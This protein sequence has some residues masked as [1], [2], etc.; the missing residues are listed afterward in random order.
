MRKIYQRLIAAKKIASITIC[1]LKVLKNDSKF[2]EFWIRLQPRQL[3]WILIDQPYFVR[4]SSLEYFV[5]LVV[6]HIIIMIVHQKIRTNSSY[7]FEVID[8]IVGEV[9][10]RF[11]SPLFT[12]M[13]VIAAVNN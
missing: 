5:N 4:E 2:G 6:V 7:Y 3:S 1:G 13:E 8:T 10:R 11:E 12:K 9:E